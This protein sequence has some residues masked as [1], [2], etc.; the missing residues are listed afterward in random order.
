M[1]PY[2]AHEGV[3]GHHLQL[4]ISR[5]NPNPLPLDPAGQRLVEGWAMYAEEIF[6]RAGGLGDSPREPSTAR[7][8]RGAAASGA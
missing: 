8:P 3:P 7:S 5:L 4:S 6:W 1:G 2:A